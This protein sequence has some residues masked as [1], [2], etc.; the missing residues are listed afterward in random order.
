MT[1]NRIKYINN[2]KIGKVEAPILALKKSQGH[3]ICFFHGDDIMTSNSIVSRLAY[4][5][6]IHNEPVG[7]AGKLKTISKLKNLIQ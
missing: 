1:D 2:G 5:K 4:I 6:T 3:F 7:V